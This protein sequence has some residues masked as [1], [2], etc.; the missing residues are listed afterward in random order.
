MTVKNYSKADI[1]VFSCPILFGLFVLFQ[2]F[3]QGLQV[4]PNHT[5]EPTDTC[6]YGKPN[7]KGDKP[8]KICQ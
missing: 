7:F 8:H 1:K 5:F 4:F 6:Y 2:M 3:C